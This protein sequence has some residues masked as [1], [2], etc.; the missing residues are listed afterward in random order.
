VFDLALAEGYAW[1]L[2]ITALYCWI[3]SLFVEHLHADFVYSLLIY[4]S[5]VSRPRPLLLRSFIRLCPRIQR[6]LCCKSWSRL[7]NVPSISSFVS[8]LTRVKCSSARTGVVML[9]CKICPNDELSPS[10][11]PVSRDLYSPASPPETYHSQRYVLSLSKPMF[12][13]FRVPSST[14]S[15]PS[16]HFP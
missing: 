8:N 10:A 15:S 1:T 6:C 16:M 2:E 5:I 3:S 4:N 14:S 13:R 9:Q 11:A 7:S 12:N